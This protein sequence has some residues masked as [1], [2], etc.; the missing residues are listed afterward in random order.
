[1][2]NCTRLVARFQPLTWASS[3]RR[4]ARNV[5]SSTCRPG[6]SDSSSAHSPAYSSWQTPSVKHVHLLWLQYR[7]PVYYRRYVICHQQHKELDNHHRP[8][9]TN[10]QLLTQYITPPPDP[11]N[12]TTHTQN[13]SIF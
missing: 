8:Q 7:R 11:R 10:P 13:R 4:R 1:M 6:G 12:Q 9:R 2:I 3:S 5:G